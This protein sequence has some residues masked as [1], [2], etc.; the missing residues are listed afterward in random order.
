MTSNE[1]ESAIKEAF[2]GAEIYTDHYRFG[3]AFVVAFV[4]HKH[5]E[6]KVLAVP[7]VISHSELREARDPVKLVEVMIGAARNSWDEALN[8]ADMMVD[9]E[10]VEVE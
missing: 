1:I 10:R 5:Y 4:V 3:I 2:P 9:V 6:G 8:T 7:I